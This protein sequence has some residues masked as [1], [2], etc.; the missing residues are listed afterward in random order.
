MFLA[1]HAGSEVVLGIPGQHGNRGLGQDG[2]GIHLLS[3]PVDGAAMQFH[4][5]GQR[6]GMGAQP[7]K[8]RQQAGV[9]V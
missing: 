6:T 3:H 7:R 9:D 2:A 5:G 4:A 1:Q 8:S